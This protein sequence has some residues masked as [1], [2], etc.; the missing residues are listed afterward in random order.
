VGER[1]DDLFAVLD[2]VHLLLSP[3]ELHTVPHP[4]KEIVP[5][6][7]HPHEVEIVDEIDDNFDG[8]RMMGANPLLKM[9][10]NVLR[11]TSTPFSWFIDRW[12]LVTSLKRV[13]RGV[14][15]PMT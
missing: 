5:P 15:I 12:G 7:G 3:D 6:P 4:E 11:T 14:C 2:Q 10:L 8:I 1:Q 13:A 9:A